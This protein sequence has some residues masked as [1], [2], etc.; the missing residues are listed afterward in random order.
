MKRP[1]QAGASTQKS[2]MPAR[3]DL[4]Q[5]LSGLA[6]AIFMWTHLI[7]VSSI[8][9]GKDAM[10]FVTHM[11]EA[12]FL[13]PDSPGGYPAIPAA[14]ALGVFALFILHAGLAMRKFPANWQQNTTFWSHMKMMRHSDTSQWY[15]QFVTGFVMFFIGSV[16]IYIMFSQ[17][18]KI[19]P[20]ASADRVVTGLLWPLYLVLLFCV[21]LHAAVGVYRL[22]IK[23]GIF[24]KGDPLATRKRLK[25]VKNGMSVFFIVLG[26]ASLAAYAKIGIEHRD[27]VG[28]RYGSRSAVSAEL[29]TAEAA[30]P[31]RG[32]QQ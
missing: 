22:A 12:S 3:L 5:S 8:L 19:G 11:M 21:E 4:A 13:R 26:L 20:Y 9:L 16:H 23:W 31:V 29:A 15:L 30:T 17:A 14:I 27:H 6:L 1:I 10:L 28:E 7:L 2:R 18:D 32:S 24:D 25:Q